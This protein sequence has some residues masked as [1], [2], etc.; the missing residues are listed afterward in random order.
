MAT[1]SPSQT[2]PPPALLNAMQSIKDGN[3]QTALKAVEA[4][5]PDATDRA[6]FLALAGHAAL[7]L[8]EPQRA[9]P[10]LKELL[11]LRPD[12][13]A[14]K[15]NL[16]NAL[17]ATGQSSAALEIVEGS[18]E[19]SLARI[20]GY[21]HQQAE[22]YDDAA[23]AYRRA[24]ATNPNDLSSWNNL[25]NVLAT[26]DDVEGAI[27]AFEHAITL[28]PADLAIYLNLADLLMRADRHVAQLKTLL[29]AQKFAP[30]DA[31]LLTELGLAFAA[32]DDAD[33][34]I[35]TLQSAVAHSTQL[36]AAHLELGMLYESLNR[37][38]DLA[39]LIAGI[40]RETAPPELAFLLAWQAR[41]EGR[42]DEAAEL[43]AT[44][45]ET[46]LPLRRFFLE[47]G[48]ADRRDDAAT[49]FPAFERMNREALALSRPFDGPSYRSLVESDLG[50]WSETWAADWAD[51]QLDDPT[52]DPVFLV[53]FPRSGTTLLDTMLMGLPT[54]SVL[55]ERPMVA[56][57]V[58]Q[59]GDDDLRT[60]TTDRIA[61]LRTAYFEHAKKY[62][63]DSNR[64]LVDKH[65]LNMARVPLIHRLFPKARFILAE[66]HPYD[67]VLSCFMANFQ[68][69]VAMRS[70]TSLDEAARTYD[71]V[72]SAWHR[73]KTLFP[74]D[75]HA[76]RYERLVSDPAAE[77]A[78]LVKWLG[79][80]WH[81]DLLDHQQTATRRE[82]VRTASYS[83]IGEQLY[84]R[85]RD[86]WRRYA[87]KM[88]PVL[89][90]LQPWAERMGY[91]TE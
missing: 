78:P 84:T 39:A 87:D 13:R 10:Y 11:A 14:T 30:N 8:N 35:E 3:I 41:R 48:I 31:Q 26:T 9:I 22:R 90:I 40:D 85:S 65:P 52:R 20:E 69:N 77:L 49:A 63:W 21:I 79:E 19:A 50:K 7:L 68:L 83:Q 37:V 89:P 33:M 88:A 72:F 28:A 80:E 62:G 38:E 29:D 27:E 17:L 34:A 53:G 86:R 18:P 12:D 70:F 59:L 36:G 45:P 4:A 91:E 73:G 2:T 1:R 64:W 81:D 51:V 75:V 82:R 5:L 76:V 71:A 60:L 67:V 74:I 16:A 47:G 57:I 23:M 25:G 32:N 58:S 44:I 43:V 55:E 61:E 54:V 56:K 6:P 66:R 46:I 24:L 15:A 42:F